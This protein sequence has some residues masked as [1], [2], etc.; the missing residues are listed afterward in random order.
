M[1]FKVVFNRTRNSCS[2]FGVALLA[3]ADQPNM[4]LLV[5]LRH[6]N[7]Y[8][9]I[10]GPTCCFIFFFDDDD[11]DIA[12]FVRNIY[13]DRLRH[14]RRH[15]FI[16]GNCTLSRNDVTRQFRGFDLTVRTYRAFM[17]ILLSKRRF[18]CCLNSRNHDQR[19]S[20]TLRSCTHNNQ[21]EILVAK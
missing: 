3:Q 18:D 17:M 6:K 10:V 14:F 2:F 7:D 5:T 4:L 15:L 20:R 13:C 11:D 19:A 9:S 21:F 8:K 16:K 12:S 1:Y